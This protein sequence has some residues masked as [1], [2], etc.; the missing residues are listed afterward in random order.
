[1]EFIKGKNGTSDEAVVLCCMKKSNNPVEYTIAKGGPLDIDVAKK[2]PGMKTSE[3]CNL[4]CFGPVFSSLHADM[5]Y[6]HRNSLIPSWNTGVVKIWI[7][8]KQCDSRTNRDTPTT[9]KRKTS[10]KFEPT[11]ELTV[12]LQQKNNFCLLIQRPGQLIRHNGM[13]VHAVITAID[14]LVNLTGFSLSIGRRDLFVKDAFLYSSG[15]RERLIAVGKG[16]NQRVVQ[17]SRTTFMNTY[18]TNKDKKQL[19]P[20]LLQLKEST[21]KRRK[22]RKGGF[23]DK[24]TYGASNKKTSV[25]NIK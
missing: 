6:S 7:I 10:T 5:H 25:S 19:D 9:T 16:A 1:M 24:N 13:H 3:P 17:A 22:K 8:H 11:D 18:V 12:I 14:P 21:R 20:R 15:T 2:Q 23:Q 4:M